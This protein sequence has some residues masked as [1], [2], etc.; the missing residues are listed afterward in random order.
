MTYSTRYLAKAWGWS[1]PKVRRYLDALRNA[2][3]IDAATDAGQTVITICDYDKI[4]SPRKA[5][6]AATD[7]QATQER[8]TTDANNNE[9]KEDNEGKVASTIGKSGRLTKLARRLCIASGTEMPDPARNW[10]KHK[11]VLDLVKS[12]VDAGATD[13]DLESLIAARACGSPGKFKSL[14]YFD[15]AVRD[16]IAT[17]G[18]DAPEALVTPI[19]IK[20]MTS[21]DENALREALRDLMGEQSWAHWDSRLSFQCRYDGQGRTLLVSCPG[22]GQH[23]LKTGWADRVRPVFDQFG[24][25]QVEAVAASIP[26]DENSIRAKHQSRQKPQNG[27]HLATFPNPKHD[28]RRTTKP[29]SWSLD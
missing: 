16:L 6:D 7:A 23:I 3:K 21:I 27:L 28:D 22:S 10:A 2:K 13:G 4:Q 18:T 12:W 15:G 24:F 5:A 17:R 8:R 20:P 29:R 14:R 25:D 26:P 1:E 19:V 9:A 11:D